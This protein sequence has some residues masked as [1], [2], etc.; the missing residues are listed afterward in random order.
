MIN[1]HQKKQ[2]RA[3]PTNILTGVVISALKVNVAVSKP[4]DTTVLPIREALPV[5][6]SVS[7]DVNVRLDSCVMTN[8]EAQHTENVLPLVHVS[9]YLQRLQLRL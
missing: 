5:Q 3:E 9:Q 1:V 2:V 4:M 6:P 7:Q 8:Q